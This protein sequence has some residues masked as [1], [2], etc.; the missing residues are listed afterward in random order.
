LRQRLLAANHVALLI[1]RPVAYRRFARRTI[2]QNTSPVPDLHTTVGIAWRGVKFFTDGFSRRD[3]SR[4]LRLHLLVFS[5]GVRSIDMTSPDDSAPMSSQRHD[6]RDAAVLASDDPPAASLKA[7]LGVASIGF[8]SF[9]MVTSELLPVGILTDISAGLH[10]TE[11]VAGLMMMVPAGVATFAAPAAIMFAGRLDRRLVIWILSSLIVTANLV[12]A[13]APSF[14]IVLLGRFLLGICVGGFWTFATS[15]GRRLVPA[16]SGG[17]ATALILGGI[18][19]GTVCGVPAAAV[20]AEMLGWRAAFGITA[21]LTAIGL[22]GQVLLL[23]RLPAGDAIGLRHLI[24]PLRQGMARIGMLISVLVFI[25]QFASYTYLKAFLLQLGL[26]GN[27]IAILLLAYGLAGV[28]ATV[29]GEIATK[30][31]L[32]RT[33]LVTGIVLAAVILAAP[34][35]GTSKPAISALVAIWGLAFGIIPM[36]ITIWMFRAVP[37]HPEAG[38]AL[39]V[40]VVQISLS[41]GALIGGRI[42]DGF[43]LAMTMTFGGVLMLLAT[44]TVL[45]SSRLAWPTPR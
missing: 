22:L 20:I 42:V 21:L 16:A 32:R 43:G 26:D 4:H 1:I 19:L 6:D 33:M 31:S 28:V 36:G 34:W 9:V 5:I 2:S 39:L 8:G 45:L 41:M 12:A 14:A 38:Q 27:Y 15:V 11:G 24:S 3:G 23:P 17:K 37:D 10:V 25:G 44:A 18:S 30:R 7:W 29:I 40:S 35:V 13:L